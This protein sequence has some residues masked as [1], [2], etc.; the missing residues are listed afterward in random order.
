MNHPSGSLGPI[1]GTAAVG[2][3]A[4]RRAGR[5]SLIFLAVLLV[6]PAAARCASA[7]TA[8]ANCTTQATAAVALGENLVANA[9]AE[10]GTVSASG[11]DVVGDIPGWT[12]TGDVTVA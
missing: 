9:G 5:C 1:A 12:R 7:R 3:T 11:L 4:C 10:D 8:R 6:L 2:K